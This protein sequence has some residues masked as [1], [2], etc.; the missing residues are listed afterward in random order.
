MSPG[1][2]SRTARARSSAPCG[3][4]ARSSSCGGSCRAR[5]PLDGCCRSC[6]ELRSSPPAR[7][8]SARRSCCSSSSCSSRG[9]S[10][11]WCTNS[12]RC[13]RRT[14]P[15]CVSPTCWRF[16]PTSSTTAPPARRRG[17]C[18]SRRPTSTSTTATIDP[19]WHRS[20][21][22]SGPGARSASSVAPAAARRRS[23]AWCCDSSSRPAVRSRS[24]TSRSP[25]SPWSNSAAAWRSSRRRSSCSPAPCATT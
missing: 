20:T 22:T 12:R 10:R 4:S 14:V 24:A 9:R 1:G 17:R 16:D 25:T 21:C 6:S 11:R 2:S 23:P 7:S 15:W 18:R 19:C 5:S 3:V 8:R 13:R